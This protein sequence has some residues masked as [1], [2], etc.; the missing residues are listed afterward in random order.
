M[1]AD[2]LNW[3]VMIIV[4]ALA[5]SIAARI[6]KGDSFGFITD[7]LLG[8]TGAIVGGFLFNL[9]NINAGSGI[10]NIIKEQFN[11][12]LSENIIGMIVAG[13]VG[14]IL[15]LWLAKTLGIGKRKRS[16]D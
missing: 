16:R 1:P 8:I 12:T 13:I 4:G 2:V 9:L 15:I 11:V 14:S 3:I 7:T 5:G 10:V 6:M